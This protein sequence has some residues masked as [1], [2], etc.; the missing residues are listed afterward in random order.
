MNELI[1]LYDDY[2]RVQPLTDFDK[3]SD[4]ICVSRINNLTLQEYCSVRELHCSLTHK[5][6]SECSCMLT[7]AKMVIDGGIVELSS[8]FRAAFPDVKYSAYQAKQRL[9]Q[10]PLVAVRLGE[11]T[12]GQSQLFLMEHVPSV[13]YPKLVEFLGASRAVQSTRSAMSK[14]ELKQLL[15]FSQSDREREVIRYTAWKA[16]GL[17]ATA[18]R[19]HFGLDGMTSRAIQV[20]NALEESRAIREA[21]DGM[22]RVQEKSTF[23][24]M[25]FVFSDTSSSDSESEPDPSFSSG[26]SDVPSAAPLTEPTQ[27]KLISLLRSSSFNWFELVHQAELQKTGSQLSRTEI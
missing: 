23:E 9:L 5:N 15:A 18:A 4:Q 25:G 14:K 3:V 16:S 12:S 13:N 26:E 6:C 21:I 10:M 2:W 20:E 7:A 22:V 1:P 19:K 27:P 17:S 11:P 8:A 24:T